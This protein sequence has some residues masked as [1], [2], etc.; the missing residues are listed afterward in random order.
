MA[1]TMWICARRTPS[2]AIISHTAGIVIESP[3][4]PV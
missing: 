2:T 3:L 1:P 4:P